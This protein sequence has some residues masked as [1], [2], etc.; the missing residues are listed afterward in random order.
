MSS[1]A[2]QVHDRTG[3]TRDWPTV[4]LRDVAD[5]C[6]GKMLDAKKNKGNPLPYLRNPNVLWFRVD[7]TDLR[8]MPF[9]D[10]ELERFNL[11]AGDVVVCEGGEAGR[12]AIWDG[13]ISEMK[14]QKAI[15]RL[16]PRKQL[17]NRYL[18]YQLK[19][20][21]E[22]GRLA[23]YYTGATIKHLTGQDLGRYTFALPPLKE[24]KRIAAILDA[25]EALRG[26]RRQAIQ[27]ISAIRTAFFESIFGDPGLNPRRWPEVALGQLA[28][29][30]SDGPFGSNLKSEH[31][32]DSG[33]RVI[34][35]QNI[36]ANAFSDDDKAFISER[37]FNSLNKHECLP[38]DLL[39]GTMGDPNL[40]ACIQPDHVN[41]ALNKAD[42]VQMR[43]DES[44]ATRE[45]ICALL[46]HPSI[47]RKAH[48]KIQGQTRLRISMGRL[49][50]LVVPVPPSKLQHRFAEI[51]RATE[52]ARSA[53]THGLVAGDFFFESLQQRAFRGEL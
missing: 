41:V 35:L 26:K 8:M 37:H 44:C 47:E 3:Q 11:A 50:Q 18:V 40:R 22:S 53:M 2:L 25:A 23:N 7:T 31:Y 10:G 17:F 28:V 49:R 20:D 48:D 24:Q 21:Y 5:L 13:S 51:I 42:C 34:R 30:F 46:N 16:R 15:H 39:I 29:K 38:G 9:E 4:Q 27:L 43:V 45:Y 52:Q 6:L 33:V 19:H 36:Q 32:V 12:A 1:V 14:F